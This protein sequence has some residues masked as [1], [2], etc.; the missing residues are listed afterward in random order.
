MLGLRRSSE[1]RDS[2]QSCYR[3][4]VPA[5]AGKHRIVAIKAVAHKLARAAYYILRDHTAFDVKRAFA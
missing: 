4:V 5:Q 3:R 1:L 2:L